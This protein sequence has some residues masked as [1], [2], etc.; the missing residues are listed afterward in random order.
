[1]Y[2]KKFNP[3]SSIGK[4]V[5]AFDRQH[6]NKKSKDKELESILAAIEQDGV[7]VRNLSNV[8]FSPAAQAFLSNLADRVVDYDDITAKNISETLLLDAVITKKFQ[9]EMLRLKTCAYRTDKKLVEAQ[10]YS[11]PRLLDFYKRRFNKKDTRFFITDRA[12]LFAKT[13]SQEKLFPYFVFAQLI[14]HTLTNEFQTIAEIGDEECK[15]YSFY[16]PIEKMCTKRFFKENADE[17]D[18]NKSMWYI[19]MFYMCL[20]N[21]SYFSQGRVLS[22]PETGI[23]KDVNFKDI[24][25]MPYPLRRKVLEEKV[26]GSLPEED[27]PHGIIHEIGGCHFT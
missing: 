23:K 5:D 18:F 25:E 8:R 6:R 4:K 22:A 20:R 13:Y 10:K 16:R 24:S 2:N 27:L 15:E 3:K 11:Y 12:D 1:M 21:E 19:Q 26:F 7:Y 17:R 14:D 9:A